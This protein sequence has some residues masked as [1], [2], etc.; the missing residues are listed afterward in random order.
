MS[1]E[2]KLAVFDLDYEGMGMN[3]LESFNEGEFV[4]AS[5]IKFKRSYA[6]DSSESTMF[7]HYTQI[8]D[9][10]IH[11]FRGEIGVFH[12]FGQC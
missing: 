11:S 5:R 4:F 3:V 10:K 7:S 12:G 8:Y 6:V 2:I 1:D 9:D